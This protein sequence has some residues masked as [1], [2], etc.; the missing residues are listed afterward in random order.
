MSADVDGNDRAR[1]KKPAR[2]QQPA[3]SRRKQGRPSHPELHAHDTVTAAALPAQPAVESAPVVLAAVTQSTPP[4]QPTRAHMVT[5]AGVAV[6]VI[7]TVAVPRQ[8]KSDDMARAPQQPEMRETAETTTQ[9]APSATAPVRRAST[10]TALPVAG[11]RTYTESPR[12]PPVRDAVT[13]TAKLE[14]AVSAAPATTIDHAVV[15][16]ESLTT[17]PAA[18]PIATAPSPA[19]AAPGSAATIT[20]CLEM[21]TDGKEFRLAEAEGADAP[22]SRSWRTGFLKKRTAP[23]A[24]VGTSDP[25]ELRKS[26]GRRVAATGLLSNRELQVNS[27]RVVGSSCN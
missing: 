24:L 21:S 10:V 8:P 20:G 22:K 2:K 11:T 27:L 14:K 23:V 13:Q 3:R 16:N 26:V 18:A 19:L 4:W 12:K 7:A 6:L 15:A 9:P 1:V 5:L 25:L 17:T